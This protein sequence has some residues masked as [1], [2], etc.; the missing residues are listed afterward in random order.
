MSTAAKAAAAGLLLLL[1]A[2]LGGYFLGRRVPDLQAPISIEDEMWVAD[3]GSVHVVLRDAK[4][5]RYAI[6]VEGSLRVPSSNFEVYVQPWFP[7]FPVPIYVA[8]D[9]EEE[10]ALLAA[11]EAWSNQLASPKSGAHSLAQVTRVLRSRKS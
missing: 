11:V 2:L 3:G 5:R 4:G 9:S 10:Q 7:Y 8:K 1:A 6:G